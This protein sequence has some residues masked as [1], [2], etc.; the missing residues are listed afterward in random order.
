MRTAFIEKNRAQSN[1]NS[2]YEIK[3]KKSSWKP[4]NS[5]CEE[6]VLDCDSC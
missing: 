4:K 3:G 5:D 6:L 1:S 2:V